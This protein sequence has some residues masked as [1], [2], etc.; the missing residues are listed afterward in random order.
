VD[1]FRADLQAAQQAASTYGVKL[2]SLVFPRNQF[3]DDYLRVCYE[4]GFESVRSNPRDWF[5]HIESTQQEGKWKRL[6]RGLDAYF[7]VGKKNTYQVTDVELRD[8]FPIC[9]P[10][11]RLL[12]PYRPK[13]FVLNDLKLNRIISEMKRAAKAGEV[14]HLWWHPHNFGNH[15]EQSLRALEKILQSFKKC[16]EDFGMTGLNMGEVTQLIRHLGHR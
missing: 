14:Y 12:R 16:T 9:L 2:K 4:Q 15:P 3:N 10:A 8:G 6:N 5:W 11:S 1:Q 13:E 7:P